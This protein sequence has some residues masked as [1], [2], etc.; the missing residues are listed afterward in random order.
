MRVNVKQFQNRSVVTIVQGDKQIYEGLFWGTRIETKRQIKELVQ[1]TYPGYKI[2]TTC[3]DDSEPKKQKVITFSAKPTWDG[4]MSAYD[5]ML[6]QMV[7]EPYSDEVARRY[8][9]RRTIL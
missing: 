7:F 5:A 8:M 1:K 3:Y 6:K 9:N 4:M 2:V